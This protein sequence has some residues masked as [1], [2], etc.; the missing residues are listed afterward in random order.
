MRDSPFL[1][2]WTNCL[3]PE[4]WI[5]A[6]DEPL[7]RHPVKLAYPVQKFHISPIESWS[8]SRAV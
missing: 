1:F 4:A 5:D 3:K 7:R 6:P 8:I 2:G